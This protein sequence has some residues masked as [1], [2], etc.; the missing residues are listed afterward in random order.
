[1]R[2]RIAFALLV[3]FVIPLYAGAATVVPTATPAPAPLVCKGGIAGDPAGSKVFKVSDTVAA[4]V[5]AYMQQVVCANACFDENI[6]FATSL[7]LSFEG[8]SANLTVNVKTTNKCAKTTGDPRGLDAAKNNRGCTKGQ[9]TPSATMKTPA[10]DIPEMGENPALKVPSRTIGPKNRCDVALLTNIDS[11]TKA[12]AGGGIPKEGDVKIALDNLD[13]NTS[14]ISTGPLDGGASNTLSSALQNNLGFTAGEADELAA[15]NPDSVRSMLDAFAKGDVQALQTAATKAGV[16]LN[17][18][19]LKQLAQLTPAE[20]AAREDLLSLPPNMSRGR[21]I[22]G[23]DTPPRSDA[24]AV[25]EQA[26]CAIATIESGSCGGN[27][28]AVGP[29]TNKGNRAYGKYQVMDFN[30]PSWTREACGQAMNVGQF[31]Y[32]SECQEQVFGQKFSQ[33]M[34]QYGSPENAAKVWFGGPGA[35]NNSSASDGGTTVAGYAS[36][37]SQLFEG[38]IPFG[39]T[40]SPYT[41]GAGS[42][43]SN[44]SP[45]GGGSSGNPLGALFSS[46]FGGGQPAGGSTSDIFTGGN[47]EPQQQPPQQQPVQQPVSQQILPQIQ[48]TPQ[49]IPS[50]AALIVQPKEVVRGN[51]VTVSWSSVGTSQNSPCQVFMQSSSTNI[52]VG[53]GNEGSKR[54]DTNTGMTAGIWNFTLQCTAFSGSSLLQQATSVSIK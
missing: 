20:R 3:F 2:I 27:Y 22:T 54:V 34:Q 38:A 32:S 35:L 21:P 9:T 26:K 15:K 48:G 33:Y 16:T 6:E 41:S 51:P 1:M 50:V 24:A 7:L 25:L 47:T 36:R 43:F 53:Q 28:G 39:G 31:V 37:F 30:I 42:P 17:Q 44:V 45:F 29:R 19:V 10:L 11:M 46:W 8:I 52:L 5:Q 40:G 14:D 12:L 4:E 49:G 18:D 23:F 13:K